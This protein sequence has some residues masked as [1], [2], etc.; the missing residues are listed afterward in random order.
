M[1]DLEVRLRGTL[2][3]VGLVGFFFPSFP[4]EPLPAS[5]PQPPRRRLTP[6]LASIFLTSSPAFP[7]P[8]VVHDPASEG[9]TRG[10]VDQNS[11]D[12]PEGGRWAD[13]NQFFHSFS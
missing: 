4:M 9:L 6:P 5:P 7:Q 11:Q 3:L 8:P 2:S 1:S 10:G 13:K 12:V